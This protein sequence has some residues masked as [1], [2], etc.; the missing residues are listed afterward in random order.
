MSCTNNYDNLPIVRFKISDLNFNG[1]IDSGA[2]ISLIQPEI[3]EMIKG[4]TKIEYISRRVRIQTIDHNTIP[5][6]S[7]INL[8]FKIGNKWFNNQFFVTKHEWNNSKY[9]AI[10]GY[11]FLQRNKVIIDVN[12]KNLIVDNMKINYNECNP[13][14]NNNDDSDDLMESENDYLNEISQESVNENIKIQ[15][16]NEHDYETY[17]DNSENTNYNVKVANN[18]KISPD[19]SQIVAVK[20]PTILK[21]Q[22]LIFSPKQSKSNYTIFESLHTANFQD[23]INMVIE[24]N[25]DK[26]ILIRKKTILGNVSIFDLKNLIK[27]QKMQTYQ[28]NNINK[29]EILELRKTELLPSD[30][31]LDHLNVKEKEE[32]LQLLMR[33]YKI[34]SKSYKTLGE[35]S[36]VVPDF[37]LMHS[38][39]LQTKPYP[40]PNIAKKYAQ[41]EIQKLLDAGIIEPSTS[42]YS[43]PILFVKKKSSSNDSTEEPKFRMVIDFRLL[44]CITESFKI[45][46]P[47][48]SDIIA[49]IAG[50]KLYCVL[51]LKSAF[52]QI[53]LK[54]CDK[55]KLAFC[56]EMGNF[57]P[58]RLPFGS[59]NST[60]YFH[61]LIS[62]CLKDLTGKNLQFFLDDIIIAADNL[63]ELKSTLQDVF[64]RLEKF[65]LT[66]DPAKLQLCKSEITYLGFVLNENGFSP[67]EAN[68]SKVSNFPIP[69]N[70]KQV[71]AFLG[72]LNY[73]R[74]LIFNYAEIVQPI[75]N[76]TKKKVPFVWSQQCQLAFEKLQNIILNKP[77][78]KNFDPEKHIYLITDASKIGLCGILLQKH[79]EKFYPLEFY[80]RQLKPSESNYPSI[81]RELLAIFASVRHFHEQLYGR[82]FTILTDAKP[83]TYHINL[84]KQPEIVSRWLI[85][86]QDFQYEIKHIKGLSNPA[87]FLSRMP[88]DSTT[89]NNIIFEIPNDLSNENILIYQKKDEKLKQITTDIINDRYKGK[90]KYFIDLDSKLLMIKCKKNKSYVKKIVIPDS[91][92]K[93][94]LKNAHIPHF[95]IQKTF[96]FLN[97]KFFWIGMYVDTKNFVASCEQCLKNK[98]KA[99]I[100]KTKMIP[101]QHLSPGECIAIDIIG[102]LPRSSDNKFYILTIIDHYSRFLEAFPLADISSKHI[103]KCLNQYFSNFG[104]PKIIISDNGTN[105]CS[106]EIEEFYKIMGIQHRK[107]SIYYPQSNGLL[108]RVHRTLKESISSLSEKTFEW[109]ERLLTFKIYYNNSVHSVTNFAPSELFFG[110]TLNIP[111]DMNNEPKLT[112]EPIIYHKNII[113]H[114]K[115][116]K[117]IF[118]KNENNYFEKNENKIKGRNVPKFKLND[119][120]YIKDFN[121]TNVFQPKYKG[122][123]TVQK[124]LR[125]DN[126]VLNNEEED[127]AVKFHVSKIF[128]KET[129]R[130]ILQ[131]N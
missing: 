68:I 19:S 100:T 58:T 94:C 2:N 102:R 25:S 117:E 37:N 9:H 15:N 28:V 98:P 82:N 14:T 39:P 6:M 83:L 71:Q 130:K 93:S 42:S 108:E 78:L 77:T 114:I 32:M 99:A 61:T 46:L 30:F 7:A 112:D 105:F 97:K 109:S 31:D 8:K 74:G 60:A 33:N 49:N 91:L 128:K 126:Y 52:F 87:D 59:K 43:F 95:G 53:K 18:I 76:L 66:L 20:I 75:V 127:K 121:H 125:N 89:V 81:R 29:A 118:A 13:N 50:R 88:Q 90:L 4:K 79:N 26:E 72:M 11:D 107:C 92:K 54:E 64:D 41:Q 23:E 45:C 44:N 24:N 63:E 122:P 40:I 3:L 56:T 110:R 120:V 96:N 1:L 27:P 21:D 84:E 12:A 131:D 116:I 17:L 119:T 115:N 124:I 16:Y 113:E 10:L 36:E 47:K 51:D 34:F 104:I 73:F 103:I 111:L 22:N 106:K 85:Y 67:S 65:N 86:L 35:T 38:F 5:Y 69:K 70:V 55:H 129:P 101:K 48:I 62:K 123:Y 80:S 57:Q